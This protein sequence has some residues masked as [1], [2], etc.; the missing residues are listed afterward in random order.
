MSEKLFISIQLPQTKLSIVETFHRDI[1]ILLIC[2]KHSTR[3]LLIGHP[4]IFF[5]L[6]A[7]TVLN[8]YN[9]EQSTSM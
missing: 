4:K 6:K 1:I 8:E 9:I 3:T 2:L 7:V 5:A